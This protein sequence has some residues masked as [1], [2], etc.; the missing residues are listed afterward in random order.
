[1]PIQINAFKSAAI[2]DAG[3][4]STSDAI[5]QVP[6]MSFDRGDTYRSNFITMR[7]LTQIN[8]ADPPVSFCVPQTNQ[9]QLGASLFD[10]ESVEIVKG[11]QGVYIM[12]ATRWAA[13]ST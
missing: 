12:T 3:I 1:M 6:N 2:E 9:Q 10:L 4:K 8:N 11:P 7:G 13:L 5:A